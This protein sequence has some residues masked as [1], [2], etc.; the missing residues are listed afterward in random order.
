LFERANHRVSAIAKGRRRIHTRDVLRDARPRVDSQ[1][2]L[3]EL[4]LTEI[5]V[6]AGNGRQDCF[7]AALAL[8]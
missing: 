6:D 4:V 7:E 3:D 8:A 5:D 2:L 1:H